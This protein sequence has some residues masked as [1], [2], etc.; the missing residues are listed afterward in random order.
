MSV[1]TRCISSMYLVPCLCASY[2][3]IPWWILE[4]ILLLIKFFNWL[5]C[6]SSSETS[7][8]CY[9]P[10]NKV[11]SE[12]N[13]VKKSEHNSSLDTTGG[14]TR[15]AS[16]QRH[17]DACRSFFCCNN[18]AVNASAWLG[19]RECDPR[20]FIYYD[21]LLMNNDNTIYLHWLFYCPQTLHDTAKRASPK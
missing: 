14:S 17:P 15:V 1:N 5:C 3:F 20:H 21:Q 12:R 2:F 9:R 8:K 16:L 10:L 13:T 7:S 11:L 19:K 4:S 18:D 6:I